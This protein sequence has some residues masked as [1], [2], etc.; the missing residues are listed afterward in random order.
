MAFDKI[1]KYEDFGDFFSPSSMEDEKYKTSLLTSLEVSWVH[2]I[3]R[4]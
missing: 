4:S 3:I 2:N 1:G